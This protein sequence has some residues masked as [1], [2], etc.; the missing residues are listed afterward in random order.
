MT[1]TRSSGT[2]RNSEDKA[3][4]LVTRCIYEIATGVWVAG[5]KLPSVRQAEAKWGLDRRVVMRAYQ[6]LAELGLVEVLNRSGYYVVGREDLGRVSRHRHELENL[7]E[8]FA[9]LIVEDTELSPLGAFRYFAQYAEQKA[10]LSPEVAFAE[11]T[12][13]QA[14]GHAREVFQRLGIPC[15]PLSTQAIAGK[16]TRIPAHVRLLLVTGFHY[17]ELKH[18]D[19]DELQVVSVPIE[20]SP[21]LA[22]HLE[23]RSANI[24]IVEYD[25]TEGRQI[26]RDVEQLDAALSTELHVA[27]DLETALEELVGERVGAGII[28]ALSPRVWGDASDRWREHPNVVPVEFSVVDDAW[29]RVA[30]TI[31]LPL[32]DVR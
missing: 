24:V 20:V 22:R 30:D 28:A 15:L 3:A 9:R 18:L 25:E 10:Q 29:L 21:A 1:D 7:Y 31:G 27:S 12:T 4:S 13:A 2:P 5:Q 32:G 8:R 16:R 6:R 14:E 19:G 17:G 23:D 26:Q 11:C